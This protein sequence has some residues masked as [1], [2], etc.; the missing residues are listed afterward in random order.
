MLWETIGHRSGSVRLLSTSHEV[1]PDPDRCANCEATNQDDRKCIPGDVYGSGY[2][3]GTA[4]PGC[5]ASDEIEEAG[6]RAGDPAELATDSRSPQRC[7]IQ[8]RCAITAAMAPRT[9]ADESA[10]LSAFLGP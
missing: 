4:D 8:E 1:V 9:H 2:G 6:L 5:V 7:S 10:L 3:S